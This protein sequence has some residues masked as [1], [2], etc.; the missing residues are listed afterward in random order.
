M[1][2][3]GFAP[4]DAEATD[5]NLIRRRSGAIANDAINPSEQPSNNV[6]ETQ[7][8]FQLLTDAHLY[9]A[10]TGEKFSLVSEC[11]WIAL[12]HLV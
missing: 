12:R 6:D 10:Q 3:C 9:V 5:Q 8:P 7:S 11:A 2:R 1:A 4:E